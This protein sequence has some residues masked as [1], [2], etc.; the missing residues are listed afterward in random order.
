[1]IINSN[2][3]LRQLKNYVATGVSF[4]GKPGEN[5]DLVSATLM[6]IRMLDIALA[7]GSDPGD[8]R[9]YIADEEIGYEPMPVVI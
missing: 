9:E 2:N 7:W 1:M 3:L 5:D 4:A 6:C 8:L